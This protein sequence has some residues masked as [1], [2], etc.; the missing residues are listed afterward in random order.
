MERNDHSTDAR[1]EIISMAVDLMTSVQAS[2]SYAIRS[3]AA[4]IEELSTREQWTGVAIAAG[5]CAVPVRDE[6][7]A[8]RQ[9]DVLFREIDRLSAGDVG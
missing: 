1:A 6:A 3:R 2:D 8:D 7:D 9:V 4:A 5:R